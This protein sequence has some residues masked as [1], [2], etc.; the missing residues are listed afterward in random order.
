MCVTF[1]M[2]ERINFDFLFPVFFSFL[3]GSFVVM[4]YNQT[5]I[6]FQS[7]FKLHK[8]ERISV[9]KNNSLCI[10][11]VQQYDDSQYYCKIIPSNVSLKI[12]LHVESSPSAKIYASDGRDISDRSITFRQGERIEVRCQGFGRPMP[13][14]KWAANGQRIVDGGL[15]GVHIKDDGSLV[16]DHADHHHSLLYQCLAEYGTSVGHA[17]ININV[18]CKKSGKDFMDLDNL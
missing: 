7:Q 1:S 3:A 16:I 2:I 11:N 14:I 8:D 12:N 17:T 15:H 5:Q 9:H 18:Q 10:R 13:T 6:L 4:W